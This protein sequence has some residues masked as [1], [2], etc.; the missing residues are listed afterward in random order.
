MVLEEN[1]FL[2]KQAWE[3]CILYFLGKKLFTLSAYQKTIKKKISF[4]LTQ[5]LSDFAL[6]FPFPMPTADVIPLWQFC[7]NQKEWLQG[8]KCLHYGRCVVVWQGKQLTSCCPTVSYRLS[9]KFKMVLFNR[10]ENPSPIL[11]INI[12]YVFRPFIGHYLDYIQF[13]TEKYLIDMCV[14]CYT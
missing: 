2:V 12:L 8:W 3:L 4:Y 11:Y 7:C 6:E 1:D 13:L 5:C 9:L 14:S 10:R